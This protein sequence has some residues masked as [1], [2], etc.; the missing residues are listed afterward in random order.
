LKWSRLIKVCGGRESSTKLIGAEQA[1]T[2]LETS[3][4]VALK[5]VVESSGTWTRRP[6]DAKLAAEPGG[7][8][9]PEQFASG[10]TLT[11]DPA[12]A[13][14][15]TKTLFALAGEAG[16]VPLSTG[17]GGDAATAGVAST[18]LSAQADT[19]AMVALRIRFLP[20]GEAIRGLPRTHA[21]FDLF[22]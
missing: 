12:S 2:L 18:Q 13:V 10:Y 6:G 7:Y 21:A 15:K 20:H 14:P 1:E 22:G 11:I 16:L 5:V 19:R 8:G 17:V 3:W 9:G 4:A